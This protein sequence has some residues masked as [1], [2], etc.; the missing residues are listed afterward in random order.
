M[1]LLVWSKEMA[2]SLIT[3]GADLELPVIAD[4]PTV[5]A[6]RMKGA[7]SRRTADGAQADR[8]RTAAAD[9]G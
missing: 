9:F 5:A 2:I 4:I 8:R 3:R 6:E 1:L 7:V